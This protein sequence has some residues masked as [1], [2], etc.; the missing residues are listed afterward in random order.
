MCCS[1]LNWTFVSLFDLTGYRGDTG[2]SYFFGF[3]RLSLTIR[4][5]T[6]V[7]IKSLALIAE[8]STLGTFGI[9]DCS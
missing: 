1:S 5:K 4:K 3:L 6:V 8:K 2:Q 9:S 7:D